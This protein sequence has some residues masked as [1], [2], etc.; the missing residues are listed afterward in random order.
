MTVYLCVNDFIRK[1]NCTQFNNFID[2]NNYYENNY[3]NST[4][5]STMI[6]ISNLI[7]FIFHKFI[8]EYK[9]YKLFISAEIFN[10]KMY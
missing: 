6:Y 1:Y 10:N 9:L 8:I 7:P 2:A 3:E 5:N 4:N